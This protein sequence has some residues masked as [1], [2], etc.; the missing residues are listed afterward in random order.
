MWAGNRAAGSSRQVGSVGAEGLAAGLLA[1]P[2]RGAA[3]P[4]PA[5]PATHLFRLSTPACLPGHPPAGL[6]PW[7]QGLHL[8]SWG[9]A[10][11]QPPRSLDAT[12]CITGGCCAACVLHAAH[13]PPHLPWPALRRPPLDRAS[14]TAGV[15][16]GADQPLLPSLLDALLLVSA[17]SG[18]DLLLRACC[19]GPAPAAC[20][21]RVAGGAG[22][23]GSARGLRPAAP[24]QRHP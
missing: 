8:V 13:A 20:C 4:Q 11:L 14:A 2:H 24:H 5:P 3:S 10:S 19:L 6:G 9:S 1:T 21:R 7:R 17:G 22:P 16:A 18:A 23:A 12:L 15:G